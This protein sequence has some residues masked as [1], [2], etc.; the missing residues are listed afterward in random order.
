MR[1]SVMNIV[2]M[3]QQSPGVCCAT[4]EQQR[5]LQDAGMI[6]RLDKHKC[7]A[8]RSPHRKLC[9]AADDAFDI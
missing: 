5:R 6:Q 4:V 7:S 1:L 8:G 3:R 2:E 9:C